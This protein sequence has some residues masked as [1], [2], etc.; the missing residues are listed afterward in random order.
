MNK[1]VRKKIAKR[2]GCK[3]WKKYKTILKLH[4]CFIK[5][6]VQAARVPVELIFSPHTGITLSEYAK[7]LE[8]IVA[9]RGWFTGHRR[10][11]EG[12]YYVDD[13]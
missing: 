5:A 10:S 9:A 7:C 6:L 11:V 2:F 12:D 1:R 8:G 4:E 3:S 13:E